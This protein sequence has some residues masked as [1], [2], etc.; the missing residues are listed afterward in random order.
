[1]ATAIDLS[2][3]VLIK[4][5]VGDCVTVVTGALNR[6]DGHLFAEATSFDPAFGPFQ[7]FPIVESRLVYTPGFGGSKPHYDYQGVVEIHRG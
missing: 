2:I 1:M 6:E 3:P 7:A 4:V 5:R